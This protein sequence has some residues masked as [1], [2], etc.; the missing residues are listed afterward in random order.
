MRVRTLLLTLPALILS[1]SPPV[2]AQ[3]FPTDD[4]VVE[5]IWEEGIERSMT[6][7]LAQTLM[8]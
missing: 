4:A 6:P 1:A 8:D 7:A 2:R 3:T 5:R